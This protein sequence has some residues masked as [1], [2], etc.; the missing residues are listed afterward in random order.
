MASV[1][2]AAEIA[3][4]TIYA[5]IGT[6]QV[7]FQTLIEAAI[8]GTDRAVP[9]EERDYVKAIHAEPD[10]RQ[11]LTLYARALRRILERL[12]PLLRVLKEAA[13]SDD[14]LGKL[15]KSIASRRAANMRR[16]ATELSATGQLRPDVDIDEATDVIWATNAPEFYLLLVG[17]RRWSPDRFESW[18][19]RAW[20]RMLLSDSE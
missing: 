2:E 17:E 18:L 16:L 6:K 5:S 15:W 9:A 14:E 10:A 20:I 7:V 13:P 4:D 3:V 1:A 11:K 8:S 19:A 12:A